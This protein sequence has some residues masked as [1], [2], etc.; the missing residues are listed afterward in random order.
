MYSL[1]G[2]VRYSEI[3]SNGELS[4][5]S[6]LDYFQDASTF[7]SEDLGVGLDYLEKRNRVWLLSAWQIVAER[8]PKLGEYIRIVTFPYDFKGFI[9]FR[10]FYMEDKEGNKIAYANSIWTLMDLETMKPARVSDEMKEKY[11]LSEKLP[12]EYAPRKIEITD[13]GEQKETIVIKNHHLDTNCHVNNGQYL[14]IAMDYLPAGT[15]IRQMRAE[16]KKS[17][18]LG[19]HVVPFIKKDNERYT[20]LLSR[21]DSE[22]YA[23]IELYIS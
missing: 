2:R 13:R 3:G 18:L 23:I 19:D 22:I 21:E 15:V 14:R 7:H 1:E 17:A 8:Y 9:G 20:I 11:I 4:L 10:N 12:M 16:Y 6:V 5:Q